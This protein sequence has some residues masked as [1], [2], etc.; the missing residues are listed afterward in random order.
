MKQYMVDTN[1]INR[2]LDHNLD[3]KN[4]KRP[5]QHIFT[6]HVQRDEIIKTKNETRRNELLSV[7]QEVDNPIPT[8]SALWGK[9]NW[10]E[11]KWATD[12]LVE[13]ILEELDKKDKRKSNPED[14]LIA[15]TAIKNNFILITEDGPLYEVVIEVFK[16]SAQKLDDFLNSP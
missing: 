10:G 2:I 9:S 12:D 8:E 3:L 4:F 14:A 13:N 5:D 6:T 1:I 16:G 7:F 15:D 11:S